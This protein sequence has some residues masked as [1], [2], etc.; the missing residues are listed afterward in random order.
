MFMLKEKIRKLRR[1]RWCS[2]VVSNGERLRE[3]E[4]EQ[5]A[6]AEHGFVDDKLNALIHR[7]QQRHD[8][9]LTNLKETF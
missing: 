8:Q 1:D 7:K 2:Q 4:R 6:L 9:L 3:L 5:R